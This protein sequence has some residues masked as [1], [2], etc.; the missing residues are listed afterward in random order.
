MHLLW[1]ET[2]QVLLLLQSLT[3]KAVAGIFTRACGVLSN[4][5]TGVPASRESVLGEATAL[6]ESLID[7]LISLKTS[8]G[9]GQG[10]TFLS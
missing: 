3:D 9:L 10:E 2:G 8:Q 5:K 7:K 6:K 4:A 1:H